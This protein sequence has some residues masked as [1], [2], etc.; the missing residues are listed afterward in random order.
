[1]VV[2]ASGLTQPNGV[3]VR[4]GALY[5][6]TTSQ[7]LRFDDIEQHLDAPRAP[8]V[9]RD[10]LPNPSAGHTWKFIAFGPDDLLYMSVGAPCNAC[11]SPPLVSTIVR[12]KPDGSDLKVFAEGCTTAIASTGIRP[13]RTLVHRQR[14]ADALSGDLPGDE[15]N[16][17]PEGRPALRLSVLSSGRRKGPGF[18]DAAYLPPPRP[19]VP[20]VLGPTSKP[21]G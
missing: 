10:S 20:K 6:A 21:S 16:V 9:V 14:A 8:V 13:P 2:I 5:V 19:P 18:S 11:L 17:T 15:T 4:N 7:L 12:I 1:M 3:A